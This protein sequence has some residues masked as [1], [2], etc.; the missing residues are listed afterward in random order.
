MYTHIYVLDIFPYLRII[1]LVVCPNPRQTHSDFCLVVILLIFVFH[2]MKSCSLHSF[3]ICLLSQSV[4]FYR[5]IYGLICVVVMSY[6][7]TTI[8]LSFLLLIY[9]HVFSDFFLLL[10]V[11]LLW[12]FSVSLFIHIC[13]YKYVYVFILRV[14]WGESYNRSGIDGS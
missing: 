6:E 12:N 14:C 4:I 9:S 11:N 13:L 1:V 8:C 10:W 5:V 7:Y 2:K 3:C